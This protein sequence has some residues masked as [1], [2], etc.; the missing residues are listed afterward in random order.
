MDSEICSL[1]K[2]EH[3][4]VKVQKFVLF[5]CLGVQLAAT[6]SKWKL[7]SIALVSRLS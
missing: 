7:P 5:F 2:H 1:I 6:I 3:E 4:F